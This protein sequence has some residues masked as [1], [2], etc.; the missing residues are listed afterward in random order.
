[1]ALSDK[2]L[3]SMASKRTP[4][5]VE[6]FLTPSEIARRLRVSSERVMGWIRTAELRAVNLGDSR[7]SK[8]RVRPA[9]LES[10]LT[11]REVQSPTPRHRRST[12]PPRPDGGPIDPE[13][14]EKLLKTGQAAKVHG[15]YYRRHNGI[16]L[17]Y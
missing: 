5:S 10:F 7:R 8:Y 1:M 12:T 3:D 11:R 4:E 13:L 14:G 6:R 2:D 15:T 9:D 16:I 17:F